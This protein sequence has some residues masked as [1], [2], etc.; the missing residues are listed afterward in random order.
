MT[1]RQPVGLPFFFAS[2]NAECSPT[3]APATEGSISVVETPA[4]RLK[5]YTDMKFLR[6]DA[7]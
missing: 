2:L 3:N 6:A 1:E 4:L 5:R 7:R